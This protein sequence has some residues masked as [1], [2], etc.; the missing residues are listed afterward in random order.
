MP[1]AKAKPSENS[2]LWAVLGGAGLLGFAAVFVRWGLM[3]GASP[4][5]IGLYR[6]LLALPFIF[7]MAR[8]DE[9]IRFDRGAAWALLAGVAFAG[10]LTLWHHAMQ[11]T[12]AANSTFI[13]CG[14]T[15]IWVAL[16]SV[17]VYGTRYCWTGWLGQLCGI[18]GASILALAKGAR[19]GSGMGEVLS[20]GASFC[21]AFFSVAIS[22]S[23]KRISAR[24]ALFWMSLGS[25]G[26]FV[27]LEAF[28]RQPLTGY[29]TL[30]WAGLIG[31]AILVQWIAWRLING[32]LGH[33]TVALGAIA[34]S[35]QQV[36]TPVLAAWLLNEPLLPLGMLGGTV[37]IAGIYLVATGERAPHEVAPRHSVMLQCQRSRCPRPDPARQR[38][39]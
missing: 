35:F 23:R 21:Y 31:L 28:E 26:T 16:F 2:G 29:T 33:V 12:S 6:M 34:L 20:I 11:H 39:T 5:T 7:W 9:R 38:R 14:L 4:L 30:G 27:V 17:S 3:G 32:G 10:D 8:R 18:T 1:A 13:V 37:I 15:P 24:L 25:L 36:A 19:V 22:R